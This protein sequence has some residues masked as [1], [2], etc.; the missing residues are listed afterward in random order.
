[1]LQLPPAPAVPTRA[2]CQEYE[3]LRKAIN[4]LYMLQK[5]V[6]QKEAELAGL[7][8]HPG[9]DVR[10]GKVRKGR[11]DWG[12]TGRIAIGPLKGRR[13]GGDCSGPCCCT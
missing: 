7:R 12:R 1:V 8:D 6:Q 9:A 2:V 11:W 10:D 13:P 5:K 3:R 4:V